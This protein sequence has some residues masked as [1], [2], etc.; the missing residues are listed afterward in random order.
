MMF[1]RN[2][3][4]P[5]SVLTII[6]IGVSAP[7]IIGYS[8]YDPSASMIDDE[9]GALCSKLGVNAEKTMSDCKADLQ[10]LRRH[11]RVTRF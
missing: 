5:A 1:N 8:A 11:D 3:V 9:N 4:I 10:E 6:V 7:S 2:I